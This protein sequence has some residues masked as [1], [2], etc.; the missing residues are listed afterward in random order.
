MDKYVVN[1][2]Q[3]TEEGN[4]SLEDQLA[5]QEAAQQQTQ[6]NP[7]G[8]ENTQAV[9]EEQTQAE[10]E[11]LILGKFKSQE[12]LAAAYE[13]LEKK[14]GETKEEPAAEEKS[15][16]DSNVST[17]IQE[18]SDTFHENGELSEDNYKALEDSGIPREFVEAYVKGREA[19]MK[20]EAAQITDSVGG[21]ENYD[22]MVQWA[23]EALPADEIETF[24]QLVTESSPEAAKLAV[25]GLYARYTA[26]AGNAPLNIKQGQ[27]SG[28]AVQPFNSNAQ[29]VEAMKDRRYE[30]DPAYRE[31]IERRLAV[32][33]RV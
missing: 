24:D 26:E 16:Q 11:N 13:N 21:Q 5:Q 22:S 17:A 3:E 31:E 7:S 6:Q 29:V 15:T 30:N 1:Q 19:S 28:A 27:T 10:D 14:L 2:Q 4:V 33:T 12:D 9:E 18:A 23:S 25:K 20:S 8:Q 32:S